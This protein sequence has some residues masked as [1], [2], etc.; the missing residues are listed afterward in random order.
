VRELDDLRDIADPA[1][2]AR[3]ATQVI[4]DLDEA[5][6]AA[7][8]IRLGAIRELQDL[9]M[10]QTQIAEATG[11]SRPRISQLIRTG[12][13]PWRALFAADP[14]EPVTVAVV[15]KQSADSGRG[16]LA[17]PTQE[18]LDALKDAANGALKIKLCREAIPA[19]GIIDLNRSNLAVLVGPRISA[20]VVQ[21]ISADPVIKWQCDR[22]G[23]WFMTDTKTG[24]EYHS[25]FDKGRDEAALKSRACFAHIG[26]IRRPDGQG[27]FLYIGGAH[28]TGTAG[29]VKYLLEDGEQIYDEV[30]RASAPWSAI[31]KTI[32]ADSDD[33]P[34]SW[35][36]ITPIYKHAGR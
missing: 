33:M 4:T 15:Q 24:L 7:S 18:A 14:R 20:L 3:Q 13:P 34:E 16:A 9:G 17:M 11:M 36:R 35:E 31:V 27:T 29:G 26:R 23:N 22:I 25:D 32:A 28:A 2:R 5:S 6:G 30:R 19:P 10:T 8:Q 21:A 12:P 1:K